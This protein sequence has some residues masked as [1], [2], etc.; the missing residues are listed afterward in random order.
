MS[1]STSGLAGFTLLVSVCGLFWLTLP[2]ESSTEK[3][4]VPEGPTIGPAVEAVE[5]SLAFRPEPDRE[6]V[7]YYGYGEAG[8]QN[9]SRE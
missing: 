8:E 2:V 9:G 3:K 1:R 4:P 7:G 5:I 6:R